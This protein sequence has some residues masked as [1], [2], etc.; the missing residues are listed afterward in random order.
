MY[1]QPECGSHRNETLGAWYWVGAQCQPQGAS[2]P[3][4]V[5][6]LWEAAQ[7]AAARLGSPGLPAAMKPDTGAQLEGWPGSAVQPP[8]R[9]ICMFA[10]AASP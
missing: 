7:A 9:C 3:V 4:T 5:P 10:L 6:R 2:R 8:A 1:D